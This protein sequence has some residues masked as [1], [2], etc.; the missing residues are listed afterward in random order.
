MARI[1]QVP[2]HGGAAS[3]IAPAINAFQPDQGTNLDPKDP[4]P[5]PPADDDDG[6]GVPN[7]TDNCPDVK[8][9]G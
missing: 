2:E 9:P 7:D 8:N 5:P 6:D 3:V 4:P 1:W